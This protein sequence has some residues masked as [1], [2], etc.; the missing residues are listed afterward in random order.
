VKSL[1]FLCLGAAVQWVCGLCWIMANNWLN[2]SS[3]LHP[4]LAGILACV[5]ICSTIALAILIDLP[6]ED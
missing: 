6:D 4:F 2:G 3:G 1:G 5:L